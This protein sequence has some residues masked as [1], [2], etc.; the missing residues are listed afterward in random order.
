MSHLFVR[1][2]PRLTLLVVAV[3]LLGG[4]ATGSIFTSYP[5]QI[6]PIK[7]Q[8]E[9]RQ[10]TM[11]QAALDGRQDDADKILYLMEKGRVAQLAGDTEASIEDFKR[12]I[13]AFEENEEKAKVSMSDT[14]AQG[15]SL[16][17]SD[18]AIPYAGEGYERVFVHQFQAMN[19]LM[20][21]N[22]EAAM[23]EVRRANQEQQYELERF[24]D[25]VADAEE[26]AREKMEKNDG[27]MD[28]FASL[29]AAAG[30]VKNSFQNAYT[31][32]VSGVLFEAIGKPNDAYIDYKKALEIFPDNVYV[33]RDVLR[34]AKSLGMREDYERFK[35]EFSDDLSPPTAGEGEIVLLFEHGF[36]PVKTNVDIDLIIDNGVRSIA[37]PTYVEQWQ[38]PSLLNVS[39]SDG[40]LVGKT[41]GE[42]SPIVNV[43]ALAA[44]ALVERLPGMMVRQILRIVAKGK[45]AEQGG[46]VFGDFGALAINVLNM[47]TEQADR[48]SWLTLPHDAQ[49]L[50]SSLPAGEYQLQLQNGAALGTMDIKVVSGKKTLIRVVATGNTFHTA[51]VVL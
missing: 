46:K 25:E 32:Y 12:V 20:A 43:Q 4:C 1:K 31:F 40:A 6:Q 37:F 39:I 50:R 47:V 23:V 45:A 49:I 17:T 13:E 27:F 44:K 28:S 48:R 30:Q 5:K 33:Q 16:L 15:A 29:Q 42:T 21:H 10:Y 14:A 26:D 35:K 51:S 2:L 38:A 9:A 36:A 19:Y 34:L 7:V 11:A 8:L 41:I 18:N 24:E 22:L 3:L